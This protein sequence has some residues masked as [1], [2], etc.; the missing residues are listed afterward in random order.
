MR[1]LNEWKTNLYYGEL[2][3]SVGEKRESA[4]KS[5]GGVSQAEVSLRPNPS[6]D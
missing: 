5:G 6:S 2:G 4:K 1:E 3:L